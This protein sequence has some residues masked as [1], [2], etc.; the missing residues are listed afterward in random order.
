MAHPAKVELRDHMLTLEAEALQS[1][2]EHYEAYL[3]DSV[4]ATNE[5]H[6][7]DEMAAART[8]ADLAHGFDEP[9]QNHEAKIIALKELDL[10]ESTEVGPGAVVTL[11]AKTFIIAV[12]TRQFEFQGK[13]YMGISAESPIYKKMVG[14]TAGDTFEQNGVEMTID[15][16][17]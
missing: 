13:T 4:L 9:I 7:S 17:F 11:N 1:A 15:A 8:A 6:E 3:K 14:M 2:K 16:L 12:S 10:S 5:P